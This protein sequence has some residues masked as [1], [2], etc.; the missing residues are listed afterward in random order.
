MCEESGV[1][2]SVIPQVRT[3]TSLERRV[4]IQPESSGWAGVHC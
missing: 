3:I 4:V 1:V 2:G